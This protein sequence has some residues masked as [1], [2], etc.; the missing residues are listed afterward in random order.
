MSEVNTYVGS[1]GYIPPEI[2]FNF[3]PE[4]ANHQTEVDVRNIREA[5][6]LTREAIKTTA[7]KIRPF[8]TDKSD[9]YSLG[10]TVYH[11]L[12]NRLPGNDLR[13]LYS[14]GI[15]NLDVLLMESLSNNPYSRPTAIEFR[16]RLQKI[17][18]ASLIQ[19]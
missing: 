13:T 12:T 2:R 10:A 4:T 15:S 19:S 7:T 1:P 5:R 18:V 9:I 3:N 11:L 14:T 17:C 16:D 8:V 6:T